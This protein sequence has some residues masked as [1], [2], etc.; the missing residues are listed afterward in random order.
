MA[1]INLLPW[2]DQQRRERLRATL[3]ACGA[4]CMVA[5][6]ALLG[7]ITIMNGRIEHQQARNAYLQSEINSLAKVIKEIENI[8]EKRDELL[9]RMDVIQTLQSNRAQIVHVFDDLVQKLPTG[10]LYS[11][12][13]KNGGSIAI[14]GKAQS[15]AR[16]SAL[17]RNLDSSDWFDNPSL[18]VVDV[19]DENGT[20]IS[21]FNLTI[22]EFKKGSDSELETVN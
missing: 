11:S 6:L 21:Q 8:K 17:M 9:S 20:L 14:R 19:L 13:E 18:N 1:N 3:I 5:V 16:V 10:V 2:R 12:I 15:N 4:I 7:A 22:K